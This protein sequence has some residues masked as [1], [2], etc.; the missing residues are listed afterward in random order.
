MKWLSRSDR[1][2]RRANL[3]RKGQLCC[4]LDP[5]RFGTPATGPTFAN[6][7]LLIHGDARPWVDAS[8][9]TFPVCN[10]VGQ[11]TLV[12]SA[13]AITATGGS[14]ALLCPPNTAF[15]FGT[16]AWMMA[17]Y[18]YC[19]ASGARIFDTRVNSAGTTGTTLSIA[20]G[21]PGYPIVRVNNVDYGNGTPAANL[22][23]TADTRTHVA[24]SYDGTTLRLFVGGALSWAHVVALN[25]T[26]NN[27]LCIGNVNDLNSSISGQRL[28]EMIIVKGEAV[29]TTAFTPPTRY[30]DTGT[31]L[32]VAPNPTYSNVKLNIH[33]AGTNGGTSF[34]D[35]STAART[36]TAFGNVQTSTAQAR[37]GSSSILFDGTDDYLTIPQ[38]A[39]FA[40]GTG[41][42][43]IE[44]QRYLT[45]TS[46]RIAISGYQDS[47]N[48]WT[49]QENLSVAGA[50][51]LNETGDGTDASTHNTAV[52]T[53]NTW[54][55]VAW[56][57][58][59]TILML[60]YEGELI[61][62]AVDSQSIT[63]PVDIYIGRLTTIVT[64]L[65]WNGYQQ[66]IRI[67][68][69]ETPYKKSFIVQT[70]AHPDS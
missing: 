17:A 63:A 37:I 21:A 15:V 56:A 16:G 45:V 9:N 31:V 41:D 1:E 62:L 35:S 20:S 57:R 8:S 30:T 23:L 34:P 4:L 51:A 69:G 53:I 38:S 61:D 32:A 43:S 39:D 59:G 47:T 13:F 14:Q 33:G 36:L 11:A 55:H 42:Y 68:K 48:G 40:F 50:L 64:T 29:Y 7:S 65:D 6:I 28:D 19:S 60:F 44:M 54:A 3:A 67:C 10:Y 49:Y 58:W 46:R 22:G 70:A 12:S 24:A 25:I 18:V 26:A 2:R 52:T 27:Q 66:E 5:Y